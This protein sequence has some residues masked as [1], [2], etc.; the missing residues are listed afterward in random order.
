MPALK[1]LFFRMNF[2]PKNFCPRF[3]VRRSRW[4]NFFWFRPW[5]V[6]WG[7]FLPMYFVPRTVFCRS[8]M[9]L[10]GNY[11]MSVVLLS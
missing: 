3:R 11:R 2:L 4:K 9:F 6:F 1:P 8:G 5:N 10:Y 7:R